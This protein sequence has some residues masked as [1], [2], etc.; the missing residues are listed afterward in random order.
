MHE[1]EEGAHRHPNDPSNTPLH[2]T[3]TVYDAMNDWLLKLTQGDSNEQL[4]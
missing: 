2:S 3:F 4:T 1:E